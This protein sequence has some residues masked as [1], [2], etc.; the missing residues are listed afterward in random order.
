[1]GDMNETCK[2]ALIIGV[3]WVGALLIS[4]GGLALSVIV[5]VAILRW[6]GVLSCLT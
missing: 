2:G 3:V 6:L 4:L 5:V 1:M